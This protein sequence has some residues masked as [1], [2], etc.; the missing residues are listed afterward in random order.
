[1]FRGP[2]G[3]RVWGLIE[4]DGL[5]Q[6]WRYLMILTLSVFDIRTTLLA[7]VLTYTMLFP[8]SVPVWICLDMA[9]ATAYKYLFCVLSA[10]TLRAT[11]KA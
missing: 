3:N 7:L 4:R 6:G 9:V 10:P 2:A 8:A 11:P 5:S 1:M